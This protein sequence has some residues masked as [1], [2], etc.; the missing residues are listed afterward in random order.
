MHSR[1]RKLRRDEGALLVT[2]HVDLPETHRVQ[3]VADAGRDFHDRGTGGGTIRF[4]AAREIGRVDRTVTA[5]LGQQPLEDATGEAGRV[6]AQ[7]GRTLLETTPGRYSVVDVQLSE[8]A[9]EI[10]PPNA[11]LGL[12]RSG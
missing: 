11:R 9:L 5:E 6:Q 2:Q 8:P 12:A 7:Q 1:N 3:E 4:P 10:A